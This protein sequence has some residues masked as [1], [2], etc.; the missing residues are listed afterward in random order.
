M[1][2]LKNQISKYGNKNV[3]ILTA[4]APESQKAIFEWLKSQGITLPYENITGLGNSTGNAKAQWIL[5]K[6]AE[7]YNDIYFVNVF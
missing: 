6:Y 2:K 3:F 4:R 7:G 5:D 1:Q